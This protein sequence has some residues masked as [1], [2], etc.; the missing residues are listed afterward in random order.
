MKRIG[1]RGIAYERAMEPGYLKSLC[2]TYT[3]F[4]HYYDEAPLL[5]VNA[6]DINLVENE[7]DYQALLEQMAQVKSGR[8][9]FNPMPESL[10]VATPGDKHG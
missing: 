1:K 8:H 3:R 6:T 5:I 9:Y 10:R 4:F 2:E 7:K